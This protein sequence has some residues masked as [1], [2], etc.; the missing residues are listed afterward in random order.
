[1]LTKE[2]FN[3]RFGITLA[4]P[5]AS[6]EDPQLVALVRQALAYRKVEGAVVEVNGGR[7]AVS[8]GE[9]VYARINGAVL[10]SS[11]VID[12]GRLRELERSG[13]SFAQILGATASIA[14]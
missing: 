3:R 9:P 8:L 1:M 10:E 12:A 11:S 4:V 13:V 2:T 14:S 6:L 7:V 5:S